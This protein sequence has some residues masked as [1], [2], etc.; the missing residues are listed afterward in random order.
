M[1]L[2]ESHVWWWVLGALPA[3]LDL[4]QLSSR[5]GAFNLP[6]PPFQL[7]GLRTSNLNKEK[8]KWGAALISPP[9]LSFCVLFESK[10]RFSSQMN[11]TE[12]KE[13]H[14]GLRGCASCSRLPAFAR[15]AGAWR[16]LS[17]PLLRPSCMQISGFSV[18]PFETLK[19]KKEKKRK[20]KNHCRH[21]QKTPRPINSSRLQ[22][23]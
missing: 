17:S 15:Q 19:K 7:D 8:G 12:R 2:H 14:S 1:P 23:G 4:Y 5:P 20:E 3:T 10:L 13:S 9:F 21:Q 16:V 22:Q 18:C 6:L 11:D